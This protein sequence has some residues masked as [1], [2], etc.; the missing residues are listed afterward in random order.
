MTT[1]INNPSD[2]SEEGMGIGM[3]I[4]LL[5]VAVLVIVFFMY[6]IPALKGDKGEKGATGTIQI[7]LPAHDASQADASKSLVQ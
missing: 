3:I 1:I 6:G 2:K 4:G 5:V 7:Q